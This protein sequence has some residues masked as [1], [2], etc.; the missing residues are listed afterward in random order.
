MR[1][2]PG[3]VASTGTTAPA[4]TPSPSGPSGLRATFKPQ[5]SNIA[6]HATAAEQER[7]R[8]LV[9]QVPLL[10]QVVK[11][12]ICDIEALVNAMHLET[13]VDGEYI[14]SQGQDDRVLYFIEEGKVLI[15]QHRG[16]VVASVGTAIAQPAIPAVASPVVTPGFN[17]VRRRSIQEAEMQVQIMAHEEHEYFGELIFVMHAVRNAH[18][19]S[20]GAVTCM[21]LHDDDVE[22]LLG[23]VLPLIMY[24][25]LLRSHGVLEK[26]RLFK[27]YLPVQQ[28]YVINHCVLASFHDGDYICRQGEM[29]DQ[30][31]IIAEGEAHIILEEHVPVRGQSR[32]SL[33]VSSSTK[34]MAKLITSVNVADHSHDHDDAST[35]RRS[36]VAQ[37]T[38]FQGFGEMGLFG[39]P[40]AAHVLAVGES[41]QC[42]VIPRKVYIAAAQM[43]NG[44]AIDVDAESLLATSLIEEWN[45]VINARNLHLS[46]PKVAEYLVTF[47]KKFKAA[48]NQKFAGKTVYLD[49]LRRLHQEPHLASEFRFLASRVTWDAPSSSLSI[50]RSETR[51]VLG[52]SAADCTEEEVNF[53]ARMIEHTA[54]L[55][56]FDLPRLVNK[57]KLARA[58]GRVMEFQNIAK[59]MYLFHQGKIE[60]KA[61]VILRGKINIVN[62]DINSLQ[63]LKH[64]E[65]I[66]TLSPGDSLGELSLVARL[67]RSASAIAP[68]DTDLLVFDRNHLSALAVLLPGVSVRHVMIERAE[69]LAKLN[70]FKGSDFGQ[71]VRVSHDTIECFYEPR[72]LF[73][74]EP[75]QS[76]TL[77][78]VQSGEIAV[79]LKKSVSAGGSDPLAMKKVLVRVATI[80]P[81]EYFGIAIAAANVSNTGVI[82][83]SL[84]NST[85][86]GSS[87]GNNTSGPASTLTMG[88]V[89]IDL[90]ETTFMCT[91]PVRMLELSERGWRRLSPM[92]LQIIRSSILERHRWNNELAGKQKDPTHYHPERP[93]QAL[94]RVNVSTGVQEQFQTTQLV[95][96]INDKKQIASYYAQYFPDESLQPPVR[97]ASTSQSNSREAAKST[98]LIALAKS[99]WTS[100]ATAASPS[101][102]WKGPSA[103]SCLG[104][105]F[106]SGFAPMLK[107]SRPISLLSTLQAGS[108]H[109]APL[110]P[111]MPVAPA[112]HSLSPRSRT[113][114]K[115]SA[116]ESPKCAKKE[117]LSSMW[118]L[119]QRPSLH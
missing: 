41:V 1:P 24:R 60:S 119:Q 58:L 7:K 93:W 97:N 18:A 57:A 100:L 76:R 52:Q 31:Y 59:D 108:H 10:Q 23:P 71:C 98:A 40:R 21:T 68:T 22:L 36:I 82:S 75:V 34:S 63:M 53:I 88:G 115:A 70:F 12:Q 89:A 99:N 117:D 74:Q 94:V 95:R 39:K 54:F 64:Y 2:R 92:S 42:I 96:H 43:V 5:V 106:A 46:N 103:S 91:I 84:G 77:Y 102:P 111:V 9:R 56:K 69:F 62:E 3:L 66:A 8:K 25:H 6:A 33:F 28:L 116:Q 14:Y 86:A 13:F 90:T 47:I 112:P 17:L 19:V 49:F 30:Y 78:I 104:G 105:S 110:S 113:N 37:K 73:L 29:D 38:R 20:S 101:S 85:N 118:K 55:D 35:L 44:A 15:T 80:G 109:Y 87:K 32:R 51:R 11:E 4:S 65:I 48:F 83:S 27:D 79:F 16:R 72:H 50:I 26:D 107:P 61:F 67:P 81:Q 114:T 45:L